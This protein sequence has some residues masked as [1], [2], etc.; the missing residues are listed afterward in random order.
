MLMQ[1]IPRRAQVGGTCSYVVDG[2][3]KHVAAFHTSPDRQ[4]HYQTLDLPKSASQQ[5]IKAQFYKL[6]KKWHPDVN[7]E[8]D[9]ANKK[10]QEVSEAYSTL[11]QAESRKDYD[12]QL[13]NA[14]LGST[15]GV[16]RGQYRYASENVQRRASASYAWDYQR[17]RANPRPEQAGTSSRSAYHEFGQGN[18]S[19]SSTS[20]SGSSMFER[21]AERE[22][23][24]DAAAS[25]RMSDARRA[26]NNPNSNGGFA[27]REEYEAQTASPLLR[28]C[29]VAG[30]FY[31]VFYL[32]TKLG[33]SKEPNR[34]VAVKR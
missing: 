34:K 29:Q 20:G 25:A 11:G 26:A 3:R 28:F 33:A 21:F 32:G 6:S 27:S 5:D 16:N 24:K 12:R 18:S 1:R 7:S 8:S 30:V 10:F 31:V 13:S 9:D 2:R 4:D 23:K 15:R 19:S 14:S 17:R 22:R